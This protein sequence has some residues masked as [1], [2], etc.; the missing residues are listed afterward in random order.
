MCSGEASNKL[1]GNE[2]LSVCSFCQCQAAPRHHQGSLLALFPRKL[3]GELP[4]LIW[5][6]AKGNVGAREDGAMKDLWIRGSERRLIV[7]T[8]EIVCSLNLWLCTKW[9]APG[10]SSLD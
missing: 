8:E 10:F 6:L 2:E 9:S 7:A 5:S 1:K 4:V 3:G